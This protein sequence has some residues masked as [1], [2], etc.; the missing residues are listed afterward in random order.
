MLSGALL[1]RQSFHSSEALIDQKTQRVV[2]LRNKVGDG[3]KSGSFF[4]IEQHRHIIKIQH[5]M[6]LSNQI[7]E[8]LIYSYRLHLMLAN[9]SPQKLTKLHVSLGQIR[10]SVSACEEK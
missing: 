8:S 3:K 7:T 10:P 2:K 9:S 4:A 6:Q 1:I 5:Y